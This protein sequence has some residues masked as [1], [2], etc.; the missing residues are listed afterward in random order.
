MIIVKLNGGLGNQMFQYAA[1]FSIA[2]KCNTDLLLDTRIFDNHSIHNGFELDRVF[3]INSNIAN[4]N[5]IKKLIGWR[6][7]YLG[8]RIMNYTN[9][10]LLEGQNFY[11]ERS[12]F[13]DHNF[14]SKKKN[15]YLLGYWQSE[16]FFLSYSDQIR[17]KFIFRQLFSKKNEI[18]ANEIR[19]TNNT[20]SIHFRRSDYVS[21]KQK[22]G[23][24]G[25]CPI[26]YYLAAMK[27]IEKEVTK[28]KYFIFSDDIQWVK[29]NF[30][31]KKNYHIVNSNNGPESYNDMRLMSLCDH[32]IIAN[33][34]FS[35][36]GAWLN[37]NTNKIVVA[38]KKWFLNKSDLF[39]VP[40]SWI[41][42]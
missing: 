26:S 29:K 22:R 2:K 9:L 12:R 38:P 6:D 36:W 27:K 30:K 32:N 15:I 23:N 17:N 35:W 11:K 13:F 20:V 3:L 39:I 40:K 10:K 18:I 4:K 1:G 28:P 19:K 16:N 8:Q 7:T 31:F 21:T 33:S 24:H 5:Q 42:I 41:K 25:T 34:S 14:I 37:S